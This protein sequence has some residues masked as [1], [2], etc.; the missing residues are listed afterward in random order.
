MPDRREKEREAFFDRIYAE[1]FQ[2]MWKYAVD[3]LSGPQLAE[4][5]VQDAFIEFWRKIDELITKEKPEWWLR[6]TV[7]N[8]CL[9]VL[10]AQARDAKRLVYLDAG[11]VSKRAAPE[12]LSPLEE[13]ES[14]SETRRKIVEALKPEELRMLKRVAMGASYKTLSEETGLSIWVCQKRIQRIRKKLKKIISE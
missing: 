2:K 10:R 14:Y 1:Q 3:I 12:R 5:V 4:E 11:D 6:K 9:H 8:K 7:K 13:M